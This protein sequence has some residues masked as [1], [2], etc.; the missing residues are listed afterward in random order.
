MDQAPTQTTEVKSDKYPSEEVDITLEQDIVELIK[1]VPLEI[2]LQII[3]MNNLT[4]QKKQDDFVIGKKMAEVGERYRKLQEPMTVEINKIISG[5]RAPLAEEIEQFKVHLTADEVSKIDENLTATPFTDYWFKVL[6]TCVRFEGLI[7]ECDY[8]LLKKI[9]KIESVPVEGD[10]TDF[11]V[12]FHFA[13]NEYFENSTLSLKVTMADEE[14]PEKIEASEIK[15]KEGK[16]ITQKT[17]KKRKKNKKTGKHTNVEKIVDAESFFTLFKTIDLPKFAEGGAEGDDDEEGG[18]QEILQ[19]ME[20]AYGFA[21]TISEE[22]VL[23]HLEYYL[24]L[25]RGDEEEDDMGGL[26][27]GDYDD[28]SEDDYPPKTGNIKLGGGGKKKM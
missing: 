6:K 20:D 14:V 2:R 7:F 10:D 23:Y 12:Y 5:E 8:P 1:K 19:K 28:D 21:A 17:I 26:R 9:T 4:L 16:N 11:T 3:A 22:I 15:W 18:E 25:R 13:E 27:G 24:G